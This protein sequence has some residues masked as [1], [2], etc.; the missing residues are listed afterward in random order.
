[1][2]AKRYA[3]AV[4]LIGCSKPNSFCHDLVTKYIK[5]DAMIYTFN[6]FEC[7][8]RDATLRRDGLEVETEP[9]VFR[10][11]AYLLE[12]RDRVVSKTELRDNLWSDKTV[13][14][15]TKPTISSSRRGPNPAP[16]A[17]K[18]NTSTRQLAGREPR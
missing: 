11:L 4:D 2:R 16:G 12:H 3:V 1:M 9:D 10:L 13:K 6:R 5:V 15:S 17:T 7:D 8:T 18:A 14:C